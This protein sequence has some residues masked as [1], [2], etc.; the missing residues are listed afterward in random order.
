MLLCMLF[1]SKFKSKCE[2]CCSGKAG[3]DLTCVLEIFVI[4]DYMNKKIKNVLC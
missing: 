2:F 3:F 1:S 4:Y